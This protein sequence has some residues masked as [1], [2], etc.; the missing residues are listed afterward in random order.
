M[1]N[2]IALLAWKKH[3]SF[4]QGTKNHQNCTFGKVNDTFV[5][6]NWMQSDQIEI[7]HYTGGTE[8]SLVVLAVQKRNNKLWYLIDLAAL[9]IESEEKRN[10]G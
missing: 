3:L 8:E 5:D 4:L 9:A 7:D 10:F 1:L 6:K 2:S